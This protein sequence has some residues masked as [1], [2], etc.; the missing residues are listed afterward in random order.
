MIYF[1]KLFVVM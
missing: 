1:M